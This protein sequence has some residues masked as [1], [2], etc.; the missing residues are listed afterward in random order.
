MAADEAMAGVSFSCAATNGI[1]LH[2]AEAGPVE[3]PLVFLL[4]G[5]PEFW[6]GWRRQLAP[7]ARRCCWI[8]C[9]GEAEHHHGRPQ[10]SIA[11]AV[12]AARRAARTIGVMTV[13]RCRPPGCSTK[14]SPP[15][16]CQDRAA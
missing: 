10:R 12:G 15:K 6:Y 2:L 5:F 14:S 11:P 7:L 4:H 13:N 3:G 16:T 1:T 8:S 9:P